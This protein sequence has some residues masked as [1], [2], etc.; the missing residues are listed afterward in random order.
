[1]KYTVDGG[2]EQTAVVGETSDANGHPDWYLTI[3]GS[4][5]FHIVSAVAGSLVY[6]GNGAEESTIA[7][8]QHE[9][10]SATLHVVKVVSGGVNHA[11]DFTL[12]VTGTG[13]EVGSHFGEGA[14][15]TAYTVDPGTYTVS[16]GDHAGYDVSFDHDCDENGHITLAAGQDLTCVVTNTA[17]Q[18]AATTVTVTKECSGLESTSALFEI[19]GTLSPEND[20]IDC[21]DTFHMEVTGDTATVNEHN[22]GAGVIATISCNGSPLVELA[23]GGFEFTLVQ[24]QDNPCTVINHA[25]QA[26]TTVTV[27]KECSGLE[28]TAAQFQI[29]DQFSPVDQPIDCGDRFHATVTGDSV[30]INEHNRGDAIAS[31]TCNGA[32]PVAL[33]AEGFTLTLLQGQDNTCTVINHA[34]GRHDRDGHQG[35]QRP[36]AHRRPVPD[37]RPVQPRRPS[38]RLR[39]HFHATVT[40]DSVVI[41]QHNRGDAIASITCNGADPVALPAEGFTLTLLQG[42]DNTCTVINHAPAATT[43][44]VTKECSGLEHTAAQFQIGDQFSPVDRSDRLRRQLPRHRHR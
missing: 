22:R 14:P 19:N 1:M 37:R 41:N 2:S 26:A 29:G 27:T 38:D 15:G 17:Q 28:H 30:V 40:G 42:Q 39:R 20:P 23:P 31:I 18:A 5:T 6:S 25:P 9:D 11:G 8:G 10:E 43:V 12:T 24:G 13:G 35:V 7:C 4:G 44:T 33:P 36:R 16:E 21:G 3:S 34:P 32:D